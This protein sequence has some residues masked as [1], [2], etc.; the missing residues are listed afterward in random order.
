MPESSAWSIVSS[1]EAMSR[2]GGSPRGL[3]TMRPR[4]STGDEA[5]RIFP[6]GVRVARTLVLGSEAE[7]ITC[8]VDVQAR[9]SRPYEL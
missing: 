9:V 8:F 1:F 3:P 4:S 7:R 2:S 5:P 6:E